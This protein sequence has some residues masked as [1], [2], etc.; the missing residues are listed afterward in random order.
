MPAISTAFI[1]TFLYVYND[2]IF[3]VIFISQKSM[4][5]IPLSMLTFVAM[6]MTEY[7]PIF[8][9]I[10]V[11]IL[12]MLLIFLFFQEKVVSGLSSGAVK[13]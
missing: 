5:T 13:E 2:L 12:P 6:R 10:I 4:F 7:G 11:S 1:I 9:S 3:A 8:A